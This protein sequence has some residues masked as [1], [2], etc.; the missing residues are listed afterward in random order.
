[1]DK[2]VISDASCL[3][4]L[5]KIGQLELLH[6]VF[7]EVIVPKAVADEFGQ[8]LPEWIVIRTPKQT[9]LVLL[10]EETLDAGESNAI[11]IAVEMGDCYL[12][13]D[14][15]KARKMAAS[16]GIDFTGTLGVIISAKQRGILPAIRPVFEKIIGTDFRVSKAMIEQI[17]LELGE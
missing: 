12:I 3:I 15:Q 16:M 9:S 2:V 13:L 8:N 6:Q 17:L 1:M 11:A 10:L 4:V 5:S 14:D 7:G